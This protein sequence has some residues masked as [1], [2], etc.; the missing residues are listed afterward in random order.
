MEYKYKHHHEIKSL[1]LI[2]NDAH[3]QKRV[4][5]Q[6][7]HAFNNLTYETGSQKN[8]Y[9]IREQIK[10]V[11]DD[12]NRYQ[13]AIGL[14]E[15]GKSG[16]L[17]AY[18]DILIFFVNNFIDKFDVSDKLKLLNDTIAEIQVKNEVHGLRYGGRD[19]NR[20][21]NLYIVELHEKL[22]NFEIQLHH[23]LIPSLRKF[24]NDVNHILFFEKATTCVN[25]IRLRGYFSSNAFNIEYLTSC[26]TS[27]IWFNHKINAH[28]CSDISLKEFI[29]NTFR[30]IEFEE[31]R[32]SNAG[33]D[34]NLVDKI[35]NR[36]LLDIDDQL[37]QMEEIQCAEDRVLEAQSR[38]DKN[39][40]SVL[41][42]RLK[43]ITR[44]KALLND[45]SKMETCEELSFPAEDRAIHD[46]EGK[47][48]E[49]YLFH[50]P[51]SFTLSLKTIA[52]YMTNTL[53]FMYSWML[54][55]LYHQNLPHDLINYLN[56]NL[57]YSEDFIKFYCTAVNVALRKSNQK[58]LLLRGETQHY[59]P[60]DLAKKIIKIMDEIYNLLNDALIASSLKIP[61]A[62][63]IKRN[64]VLLKKMTIIN[65]HLSYVWKMIQDGL[66][67]FQRET[68]A[69]PVP[70]PLLK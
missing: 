2:I 18:E 62:P 5:A 68:L 59:I 19:V 20:R 40:K 52:N 58:K 14:F 3:D 65:D 42:G 69:S 67:P 13:G 50:V 48:V 63:L 38:G 6:K 15:Y 37:Q 27:F 23:N 41:S 17:K 29:L 36:I 47:K 44:L 55:E 57:T 64:N 11:Q 21:K 60:T 1:P 43:L 39:E 33:N 32:T 46:R 8:D 49:Q 30:D 61:V 45:L 54:R 16:D 25:N 22:R 70:S 28:E 7:I 51:G 12:L 53:I 10:S 31:I 34:K 24:L 56:S 9:L 4:L 35:I 26:I 66:E